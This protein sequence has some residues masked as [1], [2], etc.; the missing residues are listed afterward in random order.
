MSPLLDDHFFVPNHPMTQPSRRREKVQ[1]NGATFLPPAGLICLIRLLGGLAAMCRSHS[2]AVDHTISSSRTRVN[3]QLFGQLR[4]SMK[5]I[6]CNGHHYSQSC[7]RVEVIKLTAVHILWSSFLPFS[8]RKSSR[9]SKRRNSNCLSVLTGHPS[10]VSFIA[11]RQ[12]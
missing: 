9:Q 5:T 12:H 7:I 8:R 4:S 11:S 6:N 10:K 3:R 1:S 2:L